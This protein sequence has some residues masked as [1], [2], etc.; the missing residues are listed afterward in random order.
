MSYSL[1]IKGFASL[2]DYDLTNA[3]IA[4]K[5][6]QAINKTA[7]RFR[8]Q[9]A[10]RISEQLAYPPGYLQPSTGR[11]VVGKY[12]RPEQ[13]EATI[14]ARW[15]PTSLSR[16]AADRSSLGRRRGGV[17]VTIKPGGP[18]LVKGAFLVKLRVGNA[19]TESKFNLGLAIRLKPGEAL[20]S[21]TKRKLL[22]YTKSSSGLYLLYGPSVAQ[23][24]AGRDVGE[25]G[26][27]V[28]DEITP[29]LLTYLESEFL[30]LVRL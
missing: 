19:L 1:A 16:F 12:A 7:D 23:A 15:R 4:R 26:K 22:P 5:A 6:Q 17:M 24:F 11:L 20:R 18:S 21:R 3:A 9:A 27:G 14:Y 28:R 29:E 25:G 2:K 30:R 13:L 10:R 8:T